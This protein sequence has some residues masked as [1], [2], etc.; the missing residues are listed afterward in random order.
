MSR[1]TAQ[2]T[3]PPDRSPAVHA[4]AR[5]LARRPYH[6][7]ALRSPAGSPTR[8]PA[9]PP[10]RPTVNQTKQYLVDWPPALRLHA[11]Q[12][13]S[14]IHTLLYSIHTCKNIKK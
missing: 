6:P 1:P 13:T 12:H 11:K 4:P 5:S 3:R 9:R 8:P 7:S 14:T 2:L 10:A